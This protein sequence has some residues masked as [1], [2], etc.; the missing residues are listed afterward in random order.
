MRRCSNMLAL[1]QIYCQKRVRGGFTLIELLVVIAIIA[2]LAA[3]LF[4]VF[5]QAR[6]KA[7]QAT[8]T[9]HSRQITMGMMQY[10][11]DYDERFIDEWMCAC[12]AGGGMGDPCEEADPSRPHGGRCRWGWDRRIEPYTKNWQMFLC[13]SD[14][15]YLGRRGACTNCRAW[16]QDT[17]YGLNNSAVGIRCIGGRHLAEFKKPAN[18]ILLGETRAWHRIDQPWVRGNGGIV[19]HIDDVN[20]MN[21]HDRHSNGAVYG[22]V[23]AHVKWLRLTQTLNPADQTSGVLPNYLNLWTRE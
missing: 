3:I 12:F 22:F 7:R 8:C 6:E 20:F 5:S 21:D 11:Q 4:P 15:W 13:P 2:I 10:V 1:G 9:S 23:D 16:R 14:T 17:S 18:T 19:D